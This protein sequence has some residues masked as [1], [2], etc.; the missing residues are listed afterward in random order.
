M[1]FGQGLQ[2]TNTKAYR[3]AKIV[4]HPDLINAKKV[5]VMARNVRFIKWKQM[6][7][8]LKQYCPVLLSDPVLKKYLS[9]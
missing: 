5:P 8:K 6:R 7:E 1:L 2:E 4:S 3:R 9:L